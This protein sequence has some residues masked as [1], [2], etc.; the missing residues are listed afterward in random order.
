MKC[1]ILD[2]PDTRVGCTRKIWITMAI[3][4]ANTMAYIQSNVSF[5]NLL[6]IR[7]PLM[8]ILIK[9]ATKYIMH[10]LNRYKSRWIDFIYGIL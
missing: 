1:I 10:V 5:T 7:T 6:F 3:T 9:T 2:S 4:K 8:T